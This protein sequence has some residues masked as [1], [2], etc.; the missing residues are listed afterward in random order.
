MLPEENKQNLINLFKRLPGIGPRQA[1]RCVD[2]LRRSNDDFGQSFIHL[3]KLVRDQTVTCP[4][5]QRLFSKLE[6]VD[7]ELCRICHN[8][9]RLDTNLLIVQQDIDIDQ[10]EKTGSY[11][12]RYFVL[13]GVIP[14]GKKDQAR[15]YIN[16]EKLVERT[17]KTLEEISDQNIEIIF[18][19]HA[20]P[21]SDKTTTFLQE[22]L[23]EQFP[24]KLTFTKLARGLSTGTE[25]EYADPQ[26][27]I[28]ALKGRQ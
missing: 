24:H 11:E 18:A 27:L 26:T 2:F 16:S 10:F 23:S 20:T 3:T 21:E 25:I 4:M 15:H 13:G 9:H 8:P 7:V 17:K 1:G 6:H 19:L 28:D 22:M 12:G 5:C 14:A